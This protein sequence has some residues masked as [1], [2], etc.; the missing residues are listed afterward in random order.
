M[1]PTFD[2]SPATD[3]LL[4]DKII[5]KPAEPPKQEE[6]NMK[7]AKLVQIA[8]LLA[9]MVLGGMEADVAQHRRSRIP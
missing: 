4:A 9:T 8:E 1:A 5:G 6:A 7:R 2:F 3:R